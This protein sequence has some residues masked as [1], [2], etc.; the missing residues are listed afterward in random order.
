MKPKKPQRK[1]C[2][3][4]RNWYQPH[5][6]A[7]ESQKTCSPGCRRLRRNRLAR[8][9]READL[10][11][12]RVAERERQRRC[13]A[14]HGTTAGG[15]P[16]AGPRMFTTGVSRTGLAPEFHEIKEE[17]L[18]NWDNVTRRSRATLIRHLARMVKEI[19]PYMGQGGP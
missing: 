16:R 9:R 10:W 7:V 17:I 2:T 19:S 11:E 6:A 8:R 5:P 14:R 1:K 15:G 12:Y 13:R 3:V 4:C 18:Q